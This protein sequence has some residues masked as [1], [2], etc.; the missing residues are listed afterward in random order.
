VFALHGQD[1]GEFG[2]CPG[3]QRALLEVPAQDERLARIDLGVVEP[4][5][6]PMDRPTVSQRARELPSGPQL[7]E[8]ADREFGMLQ[9]FVQPEQAPQRGRHRLVG[10][11]RRERLVGLLPHSEGLQR[12]RQHLFLVAHGRQH[13]RDAHERARLGPGVT[14]LAERATSSA[15][16]NIT[17]ARSSSL[18]RNGTQAAISR[19]RASTN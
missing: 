2:G 14:A 17:S 7:A 10:D 19:V 3:D 16:R 1:A 12:D 5:G 11:R 4:A 8:R 9:R 6:H 18:W 15:S 13:V